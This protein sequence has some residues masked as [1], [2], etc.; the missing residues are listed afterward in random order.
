MYSWYESAKRVRVLFE[1]MVANVN[2]SSRFENGFRAIVCSRMDKNE[3]V[4][5]LISR[6]IYIVVRRK[7]SGFQKMVT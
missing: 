2:C 4:G 5:V 3:N 7:G 6:T 1:R